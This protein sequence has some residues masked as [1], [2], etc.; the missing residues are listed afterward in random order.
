M[1]SGVRYYSKWG[2]GDPPVAPCG[3]GDLAGLSFLLPVQHMI[4][5]TSAP[6]LY[7]SL[8]GVLR[9]WE[10]NPGGVMSIPSTGIPFDRIEQPCEV[11]LSAWAATPPLLLSKCRPGTSIR[12]AL[13]ATLGSA[14]SV[15]GRSMGDVIADTGCKTVS[16]PG[17]PVCGYA[18]APL[19]GLLSK[20]VHASLGTAACP[21]LVNG[22]PSGTVCLVWLTEK[23]KP[24]LRGGVPGQG[25]SLFMQ[26]GPG[27]PCVNLADYPA[28]G[29]PPFVF[30]AQGNW[31]VDGSWCVDFSG[32]N[33]AQGAQGLLGVNL[34]VV[35]G[36]SVSMH[37]YQGVR[38][39]LDP[40]GPGF[41]CVAG[42]C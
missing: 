22:S 17:V 42:I 10:P 40:Y 24:V 15:P 8:G 30:D 11:N 39:R 36:A 12:A 21:L 32:I 14:N 20:L 16:A 9:W 27:G 41:P 29:T 23:Y 31:N 5:Q 6:G 4:L 28:C 33:E 38:V 7:L 18:L 1:G 2:D 3:L 37:T 35:S 34:I 25:F 26:F 13:L 19:P